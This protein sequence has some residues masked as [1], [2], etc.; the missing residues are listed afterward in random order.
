[1][2]EKD[3]RVK[4]GLQVDGT[5]VSSIA[6]SLGLGTTAPVSKFHIEKTAY[7]YDDG[8]QD[9]DGDFHLMLKATEGS[10]AGDAI[11]IGFAQSSDATTVG[12]K[13]SHVIENSYSRGSL[14]FS[15]NNTAGAADTTAERMRI[16]ADGVITTGNAA[17]R[18]GY[19]TI[20]VGPNGNNPQIEW[21]NAT[22]SWAFTHYDNARL[23]LAYNDGSSWT[24]NYLTIKEDGKV[25]IGTTS[26][27]NILDVEESVNGN[28]QIRIEN[29]NSGGDANQASVGIIAD[30]NNLSIASYGDSHASL[31]NYNRITTSAGSAVISI[32]SGTVGQGI[33]VADGGNVGIGTTSPSAPLTITADTDGGDTVRIEG[34]DS[35]GNLS[36]PDLTLIRTNGSPG[37]DTW[38]G[39]L[40]FKG[41]NNASG[42]N[43]EIAF[44]SIAGQVDAAT[45]GSE[46][47]RLKFFTH[48][49]GTNTNTMT[50]D[51]SR[52]LIP[53]SLNIGSTDNSPAE[54][55]I[56]RGGDDAALINFSEQDQAD[57][58]FGIYGNFAGGG[59]TGNG[60]YIGTG[61]SSWAGNGAPIMFFQG[62]GKVGM[63]TKTPQHHFDIWKTEPSIRLVDT[64]DTAGGAKI[65]LGE[66]SSVTQASE[67]SVE[68]GWEMMYNSNGDDFFE[69]KIMD[70][71][72]GD[73]ADALV[74]DRF[75]KVGI[76]TGSPSAKFS[77][78]NTLTYATGVLTM[79]VGSG[80]GDDVAQVVLD[81]YVTASTNTIS[82]IV[83]K[84]A[85]DSIGNM[86]WG[87]DSA[88]DAGFLTFGTQPTGGNIT[89]RMRITSAGNVGIGTD[90][91]DYTLDVA[92]NIGVDNMIYHNGDGNTYLNFQDDDFRIV[93]GNDLAFH[94]DESGSSV[95]HL[96]Y[97]GEA[98]VNIGNGHFFFGGSQGSYDTRMGIGTTS[99]ASELHVV[100]HIQAT[101]KSFVIDHPSKEGMTLRH[102]SLE[103]PEHGVYVRGQAKGQ[104]I[105]LPDYW[106]GLVDEESI[107]VQLTAKGR[108]QNLYVQSVDSEKVMV[109]GFTNKAPDFYYFIQAER[110]DVDNMVVEY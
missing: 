53:T 73:I 56:V 44:A 49:S 38:L 89:E 18:G 26:P 79:D 84:N 88:N 37:G 109:A 2:A 3:F 76:G 95:L 33:L 106:S 101:T 74:V 67:A 50:I 14:V 43:E 4:K 104:I 66:D 9:E 65:I 58:E 24:E 28:A 54:L 87:R 91:P 64:T 20:V 42:T 63:G 98:D 10:T 90:A 47:G 61:V 72:N 102:G 12:A 78:E 19:S 21:R 97:N 110:K 108:S 11:S 29:E 77:V 80:S 45:D 34:S 27:G 35:N 17:P 86:V 52:V 55:N 92:G 13:I 85:G 46:K 71:T 82:E 36:T 51:E 15:T 16:R 103:G 83:V 7:D 41:M 81:G 8:T 99:P 70:N 40:H 105:D 107:T 31:A 25:G 68:Y 94:Y 60:I 39:H 30:G 5:G 100:G 32:D 59:E 48:V 62:D 69:L 23:T 1:M 6:G 96:S 75:G 57:I 22:D 93:V